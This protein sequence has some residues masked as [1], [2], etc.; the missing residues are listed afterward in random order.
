MSLTN[1]IG[2]ISSESMGVPSNAGQVFSY[3]P[4]GRSKLNAQCTPN[5]CNANPFSPYTLSY[6]YDLL[7]DVISAGNGVGITFTNSFNIAGRLT[8]ITSS[9]IDSTHPGTLL[10]NMHYS[11]VS[12]TDTLGNGLLETTGFSP[13]GL[14]TSVQAINPVGTNSG[15][16]SVGISGTLQSQTQPGTSGTGW[17]SVGGSEQTTT[18]TISVPGSGF[19]TPALGSGANAYQYHP[20]G[21][22]W[23]FGPNS[24]VDGAGNVIG[25]SGLTGNNSGFTSSNPGA[26]EG[27]QVAFLQGGSANF[28]SQ[29]LSGFQT[30]V[31]YTVSF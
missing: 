13:R 16:G 15:A 27:S 21:S 6:Q 20:T 7:G 14:L 3:D 18:A 26:P 10:S 25:G 31:S 5:T 22:N 30:G 29:S 8:G 12:V 17:V 23:T 24:G 2:Q 4:M 1:T 28:I 11:P 19:E 9:L